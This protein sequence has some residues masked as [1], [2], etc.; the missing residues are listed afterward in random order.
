MCFTAE[1]SLLKKS[2]NAKVLNDDEGFNLDD[3]REACA[4]ILKSKPEHSL[5]KR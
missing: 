2:S 5:K 3:M 1:L 4:K